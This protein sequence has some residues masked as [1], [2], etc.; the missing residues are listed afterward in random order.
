M[1]SRYSEC[2]GWFYRRYPDK[3][4]DYIQSVSP[5][6]IAC[7]RWLVNELLEIPREFNNIQLFG[8]WFGYPLIDMLNNSY[9][10]KSLTNIDCDHDAI[11]VNKRFSK[12][13]FNHHFV[14]YSK[15]SVEQYA[16]NFKDIDLVINTSSEH[17]LNLPD[18]IKNKKYSESCI[19]ALQSN[20]MFN[21]E[22]HTNC[23]QSKEELIKKSGLNNILYSG[24]LDLDNYERYM[25]IG[26]F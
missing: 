17:M 2:L 21:I 26:L 16:G 4:K 14:N 10:I 5:K 3:I 23:V 11:L 9:K 13:Y 19:F 1:D 24:K 8:G 15:L 22:D 7:K 12:E 20:N 6:Q 18:L 25:V